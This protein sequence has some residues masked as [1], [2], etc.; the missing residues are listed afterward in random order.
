[1][2]VCNLVDLG[3][4][5]WP[6]NLQSTISNLQSSSSALRT[7]WRS[8]VARVAISGSALDTPWPASLSTRFVAAD[9]ETLLVAVNG[10]VAR[11]S[12]DGGYELERRRRPAAGTDRAAG[13]DSEWAIRNRLPTPERRNRLRAAERQT[14]HAAWAA[15][16]DGSFLFRSD[17]DGIHW[18]PAGMPGDPTG[19]VITIMPAAERQDSAWAGTASGELLRTNDR[20]QTWQL[21]AHEPAAILC[22]AAVL[23]DEG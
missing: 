10:G 4:S 9:A 19:R 23:A 17:D 22:L 16:A 21:I 13:G 1:M 18:Q 7:G 20:G 14:G 8:T 6:P 12:F 3:A 2:T 15:G 5:P 11:Q